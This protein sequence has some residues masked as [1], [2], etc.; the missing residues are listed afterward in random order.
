M[1]D[2]AFHPT[3]HDTV[4]YRLSAFLNF[5]GCM[6]HGVWVLPMGD[7]EQSGVCWRLERFRLVRARGGPDHTGEPCPNRT[8]TPY[9]PSRHAAPSGEPRVS[10]E[11]RRKQ[12]AITHESIS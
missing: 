4:V 5:G 7:P 12:D 1:I 11:A 6:H 10:Q 9:R 3:A 2:E 8:C